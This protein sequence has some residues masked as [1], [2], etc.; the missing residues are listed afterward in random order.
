MDYRR[1]S[2]RMP[3]LAHYTTSQRRT[4]S[5]TRAPTHFQSANV[6]NLIR[7]YNSG[8]SNISTSS[9]YQNLP[10]INNRTSYSNARSYHSP[11]SHD[12][13]FS[14]GSYSSVC[15]IK[16]KLCELFVDK[17]SMSCFYFRLP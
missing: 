16:F 10:S 4:L 1:D 9:G 3:M 5:N 8:S 15:L 2:N 17:Y 7:T 11:S 6:S 12:R 13:L 14:T